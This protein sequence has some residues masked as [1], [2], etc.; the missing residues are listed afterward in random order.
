M[1][2]PPPLPRLKVSAALPQKLIVRDYASPTFSTRSVPIYKVHVP[3]LRARKPSLPS[4]I[5]YVGS[6]DYQSFRATA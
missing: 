3:C 2:K 6:L 1:V 5:E 4:V